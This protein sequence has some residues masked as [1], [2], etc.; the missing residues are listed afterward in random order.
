M[1]RSGGVW[2]QCEYIES[3]LSCAE[4]SGLSESIAFIFVRCVCVCVLVLRVR[5]A[6][7]VLF[8]SIIHS[9]TH[10]HTALAYTSSKICKHYNRL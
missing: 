3:S 7:R 6:A 2:L 5:K 10:I 4:L 8:A 1:G 9:C